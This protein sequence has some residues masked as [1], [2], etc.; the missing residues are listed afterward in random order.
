L[1]VMEEQQV[2][3]DGV[4]RCLALIATQNPISTRHFSPTRS[5]DG[6]LHVVSLVSH[7]GEELQMLQRL[8][9]GMTVADL[10]P[11]TLAEIGITPGALKS[12]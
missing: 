4:S 12:K 5:A 10:Q 11:C 1:E 8:A 2:T 6:S 9:D 3:V 7:R